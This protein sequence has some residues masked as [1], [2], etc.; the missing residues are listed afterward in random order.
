LHFVSFDG[1]KNTLTANYIY[2]AEISDLLNKLKPELEK[3]FC[4][5]VGLQIEYKFVYTES[6][7]D[8]TVLRLRV[9]EYLKNTFAVMSGDI[10]DDSIKIESAANGFNINLYL[11]Q[12]FADFLTGSKSF[13]NFKQT[14][15]DENFCEFNFYFSIISQ[16][17]T[18]DDEIADS[19]Y[20]PPDT[21]STGID[22]V[23]RIK[24]KSYLLGLPIKE[25]P[26]KIEYLR[27]CNDEQITAG[28]ISRLTQREYT[29]SN[30]EK[31]EYYTFLL[32]DG[33]D[34]A[35]C[36]FFPNKK[37]IAL[38]EQL[39]DGTFIAAV[40]TYSEKNGRKSLN[41]AGISTAEKDSGQ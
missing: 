41:V 5:T 14:L 32:N 23:L 10:K 29:R 28:E 9:M 18:A 19:D 27:V 34:T 20:L 4:K 7:I 12:Q 40:G 6:Y 39:T 26:I 30:G 11:T 2:T 17:D 16:A 31:K 13:A 25:K 3:M 15:E 22:K 36:V 37:N 21:V 24:N 38:F 8:E 1:E 33:D 35:N